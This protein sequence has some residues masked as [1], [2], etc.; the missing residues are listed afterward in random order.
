MFLFIKD[1]VEIEELEQQQPIVFLLQQWQLADTLLCR[2]SS[3]MYP[4]LCHA[5]F[6]TY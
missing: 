6:V 4:S 5:N 1:V 2:V 3:L